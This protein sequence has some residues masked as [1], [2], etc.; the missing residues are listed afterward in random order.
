MAWRV[1]TNLCTDCYFCMTSRVGQGTGISKEK[2]SVI[3]YPNI[4]SAG[5]L[6]S[7]SDELPIPEHPETF[8]Y[9]SNNSDIVICQE[10]D[11]LLPSRDSYFTPS[12]SYRQPHRITH[13]EIN[14]L[15]KYLKLSKNK[16]D[17]LGSRFQSGTY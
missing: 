9:E 7:H 10:E 12:T 1:P 17:L 4:S 2:K 11:M 5:R 14:N 3:N 8:T 15:A 16:A 6:V 13:S